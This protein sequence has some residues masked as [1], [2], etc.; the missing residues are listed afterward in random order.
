MIAQTLVLVPA[1]I[2]RALANANKSLAD[3]LDSKTLSSILSTDDLFFY[4]M[5]SSKILQ[6]MAPAL[7]RSFCPAFPDSFWPRDFLNDPVLKKRYQDLEYNEKPS[8]FAN[9]HPESDILAEHRENAAAYTYELFEIKE[10]YLGV[11]LKVADRLQTPT[12]NEHDATYLALNLLNTYYPFEELAK[13]E[14]FKHYIKLCVK[15]Q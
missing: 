1:W 6:H 2:E 14:L 4:V 15:L 9:V 13:L 12:K 11:R 3:M 8:L 5:H 10:G 7:S